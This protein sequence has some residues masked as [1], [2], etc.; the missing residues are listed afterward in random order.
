MVDIEEQL[1]APLFLVRQHGLDQ[2][3][4]LVNDSELSQFSE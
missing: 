4:R 3:V 1:Y 2:L